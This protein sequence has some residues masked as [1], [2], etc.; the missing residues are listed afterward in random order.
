MARADG[1]Q[2]LLDAA[3]RLFAEHGIHPVSDRQIAE[4]AGNS[5]HSAVRY[6][7]GGR[8][9]LLQAL[10]ERHQQAVEPERQRLFAASDSLLGDVRALVLPL[11]TS[12]TA[13]PTPSW[14]ARFL[15]QAL[16]D[17]GTVAT[18]H[19]VGLGDSVTGLLARSV[20]GR[21]ASLDQQIVMARVRLAGHILSTA[22]AEIEER[23]ERSG[24]PASWTEAGVFLCDAVAGML[25]APVTPV[26]PVTT[27]DTTPDTTPAPTPAAPAEMAQAGAPSP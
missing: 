22:C 13:L 20:V 6:H 10:V 9:G 21:L 18:L 12:L 3:E 14:R 11:T 19:E 15:D 16:H 26:T 23:A 2:A 8:P 4:A 27:A 1:R 7:F 24:E 25:Q 5:N 17:P